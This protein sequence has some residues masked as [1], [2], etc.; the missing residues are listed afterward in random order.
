M[1]IDGLVF[2]ISAE[3]IAATTRIPNTGELCFKKRDLDLENYKMYLKPPYKTAPK[4][5]SPS[6][7][8]LERYAPIMKIIMKYFTCDGRFSRLYQYH[9]R[10]LMHFTYV[11]VL[12]LPHYLYRSIVKMVEKVL[13]LG[14]YHHDNLFHHGLVKILAFHQLAQINLSWDGFIYSTFLLPSPA[15]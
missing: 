6:R 11:K 8:L 1:T 10:L 2:T 12:K 4:H 15:Q 13:R 7:D 14:K 3:T 5:I 9:V